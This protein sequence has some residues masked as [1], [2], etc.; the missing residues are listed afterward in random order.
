MNHESFEPAFEVVHEN[1]LFA[2][3]LDYGEDMGNPNSI[4]SRFQPDPKS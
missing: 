1:T 2:C 3:G 4:R